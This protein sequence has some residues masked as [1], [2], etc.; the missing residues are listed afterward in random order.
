MEYNMSTGRFGDMNIYDPN[1]Y[2]Q[3][4]SVY[5]FAF[6][7]DSGI[8]VSNPEETLYYK[9]LKSGKVRQI[10]LV[11]VNGTILNDISIERIYRDKRGK[12]CDGCK[13]KEN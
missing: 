2:T 13:E 12:I 8:W 10:A 7:A 9:D 4:M 1:N 11:D 5:D 6:E 3:Q